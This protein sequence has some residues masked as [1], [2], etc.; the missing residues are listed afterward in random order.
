MDFRALT[1]AGMPRKVSEHSACGFVFKHLPLDSGECSCTKNPVWLL[2]LQKF[3]NFKWYLFV[4]LKANATE[5]KTKQ[6]HQQQKY[7]IGRI[8]LAVSLSKRINECILL[9]SLLFVMVF[10]DLPICLSNSTWS[11][12][13]TYVYF[14]DYFRV[15]TISLVTCFPSPHVWSA[16]S[17]FIFN[18]SSLGISLKL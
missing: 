11:S 5:N 4:K 8:L 16:R 14:M 7:L 15:E 17:N 13:E 1:F 12:C 3:Y 2:F 18:G 10:R 9:I 6:K